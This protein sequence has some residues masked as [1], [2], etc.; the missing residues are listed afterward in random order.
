MS[1]FAVYLDFQK[2][3]DS[4]I[5]TV[6][7]GFGPFDSFREAEYWLGVMTYGDQA[8]YV[9]SWEIPERD[10]PQEYRFMTYY[11]GAHD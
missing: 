5:T 6:P 9:D 2:H 8:T 11:V 10:L 4:L 1:K 7:L 3:G